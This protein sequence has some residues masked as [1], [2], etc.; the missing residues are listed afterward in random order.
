MAGERTE[1][2][3]DQLPPMDPVQGVM[4]TRGPLEG[5]YA[6][7]WNVNQLRWWD[8]CQWTGYTSPGS[9]SPSDTVLSSRDSSLDRDR[10]T[11][12]LDP[13]LQGP[14]AAEGWYPDPAETDE[15]RWWNGYEWLAQAI[16]ASPVERVVLTGKGYRVSTWC[17]TLFWA[18]AAV[19][20]LVLVPLAVGGLHNHADSKSN[21]IGLIVLCALGAVLCSLFAW[22]AL[23][24][25]GD[26]LFDVTE[27][28][29]A[30]AERP[31]NRFRKSFPKL[32]KLKGVTAWED[33]DHV[34]QA[35]N[36]GADGG[37]TYGITVHLK[38]GRTGSAYVWSARKST[39]SEV[40]S[41]LEEVRHNAT[42][43]GLGIS[44]SADS[45]VYR[46]HG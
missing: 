17:I 37:G 41:R 15:P 46:G 10:S 5:W 43:H 36:P 8:G 19:G 32:D 24:G 31:R 3:W 35:Y 34:E 14:R 18:T 39:M 40:V 26:Y 2:D 33:V 6:D 20:C 44:D 42:R 27:S 12:S 30:I 7:P 29:S 28:G 22:V 9:V 23:G 1:A 16:N 13:T 45:G 25:L 11:D 4:R 21:S 38:D